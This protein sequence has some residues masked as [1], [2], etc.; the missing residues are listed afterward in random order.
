MI[1]TDIHEY[2][3]DY[4]KRNRKYLLDY[5]KWYYSKQKCLEGKIKKSEVKTK[6]YRSCIVD[7]NKPQPFRIR[8]G[9][10]TITWD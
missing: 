10:F 2:R 8:H 5:S 6:P 3:K 4:Y 1:T 9:T 7:I